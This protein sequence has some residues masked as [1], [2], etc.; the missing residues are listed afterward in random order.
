MSIRS[1]PRCTTPSPTEI[2]ARICPLARRPI[3]MPNEPQVRRILVVC[4][5]NH[6]RSPLAAAILARRG[7]TGVDVRSAGLA[8]HHIDQPAH[9]Q[10]VIAAK[11]LGYDISGHRGAQLTP[12]L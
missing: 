2:A 7:G 11:A 4:L 3:A 12:Q 6:C 5:G 10:M 8:H 9:P 1:P